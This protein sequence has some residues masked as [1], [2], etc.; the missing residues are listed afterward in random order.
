MIRGRQ[1]QIM[2]NASPEAINDLNK[3]F[4][5]IKSVTK[6]LF[7]PSV[8]ECLTIGEETKSF[9][10]RL[11]DT[12]MSSLKMSRVSLILHF[13]LAFQIA[14]ICVFDVLTLNTY[15]RLKITTLLTSP[16]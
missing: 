15:A 4:D 10:V 3:T 13:L 8:G 16:V 2:V 14:L 7:S 12:I 5:A 11:G 9:S 6:E 1:S